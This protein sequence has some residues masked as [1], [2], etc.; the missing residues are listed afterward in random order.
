MTVYGYARVSTQTQN[1]ERQIRNIQKEYPQ[2]TIYK[3]AYTGR[4]FD[5]PEWTKLC[6]RLKAGDVVVFDSVSRMGRDAEQCMDIYKRMMTDEVDLIFLKERH[7]DTAVFKDAKERAQIPTVHTGQ[8]ST[9]KL[10]SGI[11]SAVND[12]LNALV[13][14][15]VALAFK[16]AED[17]VQSLRQRTRE[18]LET[19][20]MNGRQIG[21]QTG[22]K[23]TTKKE[24]AM[25]PKIQKLSADC[26][27]TL[28]DRECIDLLGISRGTF[29]KYK[30]K[31][32]AD[33]V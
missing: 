17:E 14:Q 3:E 9:D 1:L 31:I 8:E 2:A 21:R 12:F 23:I 15:Q 13:E 32:K 16:E 6:K 26:L 5:R 28:S 33:R 11:I 22:S 18:G 25:L 19:A 4:K 7:I 29:Y 20:R 10:I 30:R 27:G 24:K